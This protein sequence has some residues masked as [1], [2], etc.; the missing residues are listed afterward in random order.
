MSEG[1]FSNSHCFAMINRVLVM[2]I[3]SDLRV[4]LG[5]WHSTFVAGE[6]THH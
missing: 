4:A 2:H 6:C 5:T 3:S 1:I